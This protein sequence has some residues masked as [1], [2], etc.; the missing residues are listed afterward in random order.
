M[1][2]A[3]RRFRVL[4][5]ANFGADISPME[6]GSLSWTQAVFPSP[7]QRPVQCPAPLGLT[8]GLAVGVLPCD[9][10]IGWHRRLVWQWGCGVHRATTAVEQCE[11][12]LHLLCT[13][14]CGASVA[15]MVTVLQIDCFGSK[16]TVA[17][18]GPH[19]SSSIPQEILVCHLPAF[20]RRLAPG[21]VGPDTS[22]LLA[23]AF[24]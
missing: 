24:G 4:R 19:V 17:A 22:W 15:Q 12:V 13:K 10:G 3:T 21:A 5:D 14:R 2:D 8:V 6:L 7:V 16:A 9:L 23:P 20:W 11:R 1:E 18:S